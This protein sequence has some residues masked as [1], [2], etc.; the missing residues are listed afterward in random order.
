MAKIIVKTIEPAFYSLSQHLYI[1]CRGSL[2]LPEA[3]FFY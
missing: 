2:S 1:L 3:G